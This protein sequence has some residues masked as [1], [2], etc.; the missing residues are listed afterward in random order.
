MLCLIVS[1][2]RTSADIDHAFELTTGMAPRFRLASGS[3]MVFV[4]A[5]SI[6]AWIT[7]GG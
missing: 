6:V 5:Y 2:R 7:G 4:S 1:R 3:W